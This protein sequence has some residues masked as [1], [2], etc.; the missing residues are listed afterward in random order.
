[1]TVRLSLIKHHSF[2][3]LYFAIKKKTFLTLFVSIKFRTPAV[4]SIVSIKFRTPAVLSILRPKKTLKQ[5]KEIF[6]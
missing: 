3:Y 1:M 4:L 5:Y 2:C 6:H